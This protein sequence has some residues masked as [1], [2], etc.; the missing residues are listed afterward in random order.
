MKRLILFSSLFIL[1]VVGCKDE[2]DFEGTVKVS[3]VNG[4]QKLWI[5]TLEDTTDPIYS[6]VYDNKKE[7]TMPLNIGNYRLKGYTIDGYLSTV[8]FQIRSGKTV[9][10][11]YDKDKAGEITSN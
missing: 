10:I 11:V 1:L 2:F 8:T 6:L 5:Y 9:T 3:S 7:L 4:I